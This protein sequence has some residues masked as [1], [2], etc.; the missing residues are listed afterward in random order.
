MIND[1]LMSNHERNRSSFRITFSSHDPYD[2]QIAVSDQKNSIQGKRLLPVRAFET[3][4]VSGYSLGM[5]GCLC[6]PL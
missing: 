5:C 6:C 4:H 2:Y 1:K 3:V